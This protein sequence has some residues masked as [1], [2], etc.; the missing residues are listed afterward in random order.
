MSKNKKEDKQLFG[1]P[2]VYYDCDDT[3]VM[4][5]RDYSF[6]ST[7]KGTVHLELYGNNYYL[8]P[9]KKHIAL[10]KQH[11]SEGFKIVVWSAGGAP[12]AR[13]IVS[14]LE[15]TDQVDIILSKPEFYVDDCLPEDFLHKQNR[16]YYEYEEET[17]KNESNKNKS[18]NKKKAK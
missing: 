18:S 9:H 16:I 10:L 7:V 8:K 6:S 12:W 11:K 13:E 15:L 3:L 14:K 5:D 4:W 17:E 1:E 2:T